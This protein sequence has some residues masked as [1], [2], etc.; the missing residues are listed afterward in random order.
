M[1]PRALFVLIALVA[2]ATAPAGAALPNLSDPLPGSTALPNG[3]RMDPAGHQVLT[4]RA[5]TGVT[6]G[7][8]GAIYAVTSDI[9][10]NSVERVD[11]STLIPVPS[12][13]GSTFQGVA[14]DR[15]GYVWVSGG[16]DHVVYPFKVVGPALVGLGN[17]GPVPDAPNNGVAVPG[18]PGTSILVGSTLYVAGSLSVPSSVAQS[19]G[20]KPCEESTA[21]SI[22]TPINVG[23]ALAPSVGK[24]VSVGRDAYGMVWRARS[25]TLYVANFADGSN[26]A[27]GTGTVSVVNGGVQTQVVRVGSGPAGVALSPDQST[28]AVANTGSD[29]VSLLSLASNGSVVGVR[30]VDV[31]LTPDAPL[32][33]TPSA[34]GYLPDGKLV[35]A[36]AGIDALEVLDARGD[37][38]DQRVHDGARVERVPHTFIPT[39]WYPDALAIGTAPSGG[40]RIVVAN[41]R[42]DGSGP[43]YYGQLQPLVGT[44]TEGTLSVIDL[45]ADE[46]ALQRQLNDYT[47]RVVRDDRLAPLWDHRLPDPAMNA[48]DGGNPM[49]CAAQD[50]KLDPKS[51]HVVVI[52]AEN[53]T[54][55]AYFGD[56]GGTFR[57][58]D[59]SPVFNE[60]GDL[61]T[62]NQHN[63]A[64]AWT[65]ND[66]FYNEGAEASTVGHDWMTAGYDTFWREMT[67]NHEYDNG[68]RGDREGGRYAGTVVSGTHDATVGAADG[69][70]IQPH[71]RVADVALENGLSVR[72]YGTDVTRPSPSEKYT[73]PQGLWGLGP[74]A[75]TATD[76]S[77]PD[78]DRANMF[79]HGQ[80]VSHAWDALGGVPPSSEDPSRSLPPPTFG[81]TIAFSATDKQTFTL[82]AW[83]AKYASCRAAGSSDATCQQAMPNYTFM[84]LP[85]NHTYDVENTFN[86][87]DPTPQS[88]CADNDYA[89]GKVVEGLSHSPFW[90]NTVVFLTEDDNQFTGDHVDIHRSF[91]LTM[92]GLA[93]RLGPKGLVS[94]ERG[95]FASVVKTTEVLLG[96][97]PMTLFDWRALPLSD[98]LARSLAASNATYTAVVPPTPFLG[99]G[100]P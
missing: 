55:D 21:C 15:N 62:T 70:M 37:A 91:L 27:R 45:P 65:L 66:N 5:P 77:F 85:E 96:L 94:H 20:A 59:A 36:L 48:C 10:M 49:L 41:L 86:P 2:V 18:E 38:I 72:I 1:R 8:D 53:K 67:W 51:L 82:D 6:I 54:F 74:T 68:I 31:R 92:G 7:P 11:P 44:S 16:P 87:L 75:P 47:A 64:R 100:V 88:M 79:L 56:T 95:S 28:L 46:S 22:V 93:A 33:T 35:V 26:P 60:Y 19:A 57:N 58:V 39:G 89:I 23:N 97:A 50:G 99:R 90:K 24:S 9:F 78:A 42:G 84:A 73:V 69:Y 81:K 83:N 76:L 29:T 71:R 13:V 3:W 14:A 61:V 80:T 34:V 32:G 63:L 30:T 17:L 12:P 98:E 4:L 52:L 25:N 43:G 40:A